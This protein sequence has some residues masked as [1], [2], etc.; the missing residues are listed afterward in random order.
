MKPKLPRKII[1]SV[2]NGEIKGEYCQ[3]LE[4]AE[5]LA[6]LQVNLAEVYR[7]A[8]RQRLKER[9]MDNPLTW[10]TDMTMRVAV[11]EREAPEKPCL[12][13]KKM[14]NTITFKRYLTC[15]YICEKFY[16]ENRN[17][18]RDSI[19]R[20]WEQEKRENLTRCTECGTL[21]KSKYKQKKTCGKICA[22]YRTKRLSGR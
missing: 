12:I 11:K 4:C 22:I 7:K 9:T 2:C 16:K 18:T 13:C 20:K 6:L 10:D 8:M 17:L 3:K 14:F 1:C 15:S 19:M 21:F 5:Y